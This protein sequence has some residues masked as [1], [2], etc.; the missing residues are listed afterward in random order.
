MRALYNGVLAHITDET[1]DAVILDG[2]LRVPYGDLSLIVEPTDAQIAAAQAGDEIPLDPTEG[3]TL[4]A[5]LRDIGA[6]D[7]L[8]ADVLDMHA[9]LRPIAIQRGG[10]RP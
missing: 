9:R 8:I 1:G 2:E 5:E 7:R 10:A 4:A 6:D 3:E